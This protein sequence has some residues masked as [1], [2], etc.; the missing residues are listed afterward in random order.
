M[1]NKFCKS[2]LWECN[3]ALVEVAQGR[4]PADTVIRHARLVDVCTHEVLDDVDIAIACGRVAY[5]GLEGNTA[6]HCIGEKT[7]VIDAAGSYV[8]PGF[9]DGHMHVESAMV[10]V[11]EYARAVVP[12]GTVGIY[13]DPH[14]CANVRGLKGV[15]VMA[16]DSRRTPLKAMITTPSCV[17]AVPGFEDTGSSIDAADVAETMG[18]DSVVALGEMMNFPGVLSCD[19]NT[20]GE[21][22]ATLKADKCV[23]GHYSVP[24]R[25]RGL[26]AYIASG[27][28]ACHESVTA[29]DVTAKLRLGM[30]AQ[31]REGSAWHN[32]KDLAPAIVGHDIDTRLCCLVSDDNHPHTVVRE[33]HLDRILRLAVKFGIDPVTAIQMVTINTATCFHMESDMGAVAPGKCADIVFLDD[34]TDFNVTRVLIDGEVVAE[35]GHPTFEVDPFEYPDWMTHT[36]NLGRD[37]DESTFEMPATDAAGATLPDGRACVRVMGVAPGQTITRELHEDVPVVDGHFQA[38]AN[39]DILKVFVFERHH[40]T[41]SFSAG[42]AKGFGI[43][44]ALA[45][46]VAHDAHNL[47]VM[48]DNDADMALAANELVSCGGGEVAVQDGHVL[49]LVELPVCGLMSDKRVEVV[50]DEVSH[51]EDAWAKMGCTM[52]SPFMTMGGMSLACIPELRLTNKGYVNCL[53]F[54]FEPVTVE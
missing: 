54:Q 2:P 19:D 23:T 18:W 8:A 6:E 41:G 24:E 26:N 27:V 39:A 34:L 36:M 38:D 4:R 52:P 35:D 31:L 22:D 53:T 11:S 43:H 44:G 48:G 51:I 9:M 1:I 14:E 21:I 37:I 33:G 5:L 47:L 46:T 28:S 16:E 7:K 29:A 20:L 3:K 12:H 32:L 50:S 25:D 42:F 15:A 13:M 10:G 17:P 45:Q 30:Y 49:G 40:A